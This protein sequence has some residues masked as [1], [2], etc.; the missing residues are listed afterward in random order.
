MLT[1][2]VGWIGL[3]ARSETSNQVEILE[4]RHQLAALPAEHASTSDELGRPSPHL[5]AGLPA[6]APSTPRPA[7]DTSDDPALAPPTRRSR[8][9]HETNSA[10]AFPG[11]PRGNAHSPS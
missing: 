6:A 5:R 4:L 8:M 1:R 7:G 2:L 3:R 11:S 10:R 9:D